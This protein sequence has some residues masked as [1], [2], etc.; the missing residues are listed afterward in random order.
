MVLSHNLIGMIER[1]PLEYAGQRLPVRFVSVQPRPE[2]PL[3]PL[4]A[5]ITVGTT[6][7]GGE[8][9][10]TLTFGL[11]RLATMRDEQHVVNNLVVAL[12]KVVAGD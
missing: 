10:A 1:A 5:A 4:A 11:D 8:H 9:R 7:D 3:Q 2:A 6:H 12:R